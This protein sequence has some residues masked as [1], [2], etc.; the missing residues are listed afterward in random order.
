MDNLSQNHYLPENNAENLSLKHF[1]TSKNCFNNQLKNIFNKFIEYQNY[2]ISKITKKYFANNKTI[3]EIYIQSAKKENIVSFNISDDEFLKIFINNCL[4]SE[5]EQEFKID[6][7]GMEKDLKEEIIPG[8]KK[9]V[10][11]EID[12]DII[13]DDDLLNQMNS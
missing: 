7:N 1:F 2:F 11:K 8:L 12:N 13:D 10:D 9:L 3:K 5:K 4:I 6:F